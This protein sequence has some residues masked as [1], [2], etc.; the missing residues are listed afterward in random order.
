MNWITES[1]CIRVASFGSRSYFNKRENLPQYCTDGCPIEET[2]I[3]SALKFYPEI[4]EPNNKLPKY[5]SLCVYNVNSDL[6]DHQSSILEYENGISI[7]FSLIPLG[8]ENTR[9]IYICGTEATLE[10]SWGQN[11]IRLFFYKDSKE[12]FYDTVGVEGHGGADSRIVSAFLD[13]LDNIHPT[14]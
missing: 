2:C 13:Y 9:V 10:G 4:K 11:K 7:C 5:K 3:F 6:V 14:M 1:K 8:S 12:I